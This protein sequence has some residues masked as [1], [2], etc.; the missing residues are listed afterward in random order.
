MTDDVLEE[1]PSSS[2]EW[3]PGGWPRLNVTTHED[4][5]I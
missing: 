3:F 2:W 5:E 1:A 4:A